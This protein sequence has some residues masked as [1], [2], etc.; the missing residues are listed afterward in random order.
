MLNQQ[1]QVRPEIK[2]DTLMSSP[3][4]QKAAVIS[5]GVSNL[6]ATAGETGP[7]KA[8]HV[9]LTQDYASAPSSGNNTAQ[10]NLA[11]LRRR[12]ATTMHSTKPTN[13]SSPM[14]QSPPSRPIDMM[15]LTATTM[16]LLP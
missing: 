9:N 2:Y 12:V 6:R 16:N 7:I 1:Q 10:A 3:S 14:P 4:P 8:Y 11:A 5:K 13:P 15:G